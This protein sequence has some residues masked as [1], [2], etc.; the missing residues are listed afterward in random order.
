M[1]GRKKS[2][3][4]E[5]WGPF[6]DTY[7]KPGQDGFIYEQDIPSYREV[8]TPHGVYGVPAGSILHFEDK[9]IIDDGELVVI[10]SAVFKK[11]KASVKFKEPKKTDRRVEG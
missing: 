11:T 1:A 9:E 3:G 8:S 5:T 7:E 6:Y 4:D 2:S 10:P